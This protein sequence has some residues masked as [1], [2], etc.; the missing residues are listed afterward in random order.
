[1]TGINTRSQGPGV[2]VAASS[3]ACAWHDPIDGRLKE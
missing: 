3:F 2:R 1:V